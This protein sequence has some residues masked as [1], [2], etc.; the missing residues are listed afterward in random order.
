MTILTTH[1]SLAG[2]AFWSFL[3]PTEKNNFKEKKYLFWIVL[4]FSII[5]DIDIFL[6]IHR[7]LSHSLIP[8]TLLVILGISIHILNQYKI[9][10]GNNST[11]NPIHYKNAFRAALPD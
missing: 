9:D 5:P 10:L 3:S 8:P 6:G 1:L 2:I 4:V 7:G 11:G